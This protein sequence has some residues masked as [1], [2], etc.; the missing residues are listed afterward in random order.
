MHAARARSEGSLGER[1]AH[2]HVHVP[3]YAYASGFGP[4]TSDPSGQKSSIDVASC[5]RARMALRH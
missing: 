3:D 1:Y 5:R 4:R 2:A